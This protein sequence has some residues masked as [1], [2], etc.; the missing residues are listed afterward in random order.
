L[1]RSILH[2]RIIIGV[3]DSANN[4]QKTKS[5][6]DKRKEKKKKK[7]TQLAHQRYHTSPTWAMTTSFLNFPH[8]ISC[9]T[10]SAQL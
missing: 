6:K 1:P 5:W 2:S 4:I 3:D 8:F 10:R 9:R 7:K